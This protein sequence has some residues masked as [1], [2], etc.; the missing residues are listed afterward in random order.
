LEHATSTDKEIRYKCLL[1]LSPPNW[2]KQV[3]AK[4]VFIEEYTPQLWTEITVEYSKARGVE[5]GYMEAKA[6]GLLAYSNWSCKHQSQQTHVQYLLCSVQT[7]RVP[8]CLFGERFHIDAVCLDKLEKFLI[9]KQF[10]K[11]RAVISRYSSKKKS[12]NIFVLQFRQVFL[13]PN[14][15]QKSI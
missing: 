10:S 5:G 11:K 9:M 2:K 3:L 6:K 15:P 1:W 7:K 13:N 4:I 14:F 12:L 8:C